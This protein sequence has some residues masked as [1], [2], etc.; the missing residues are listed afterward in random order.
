M[1]SLFSLSSV[2]LL[3]GGRL[4]FKENLRHF[5]YIGVFLMIG[6]A[7]I[8]SFSNPGGGKTIEV[9]G[10]TITTIPSYQAVLLGL[11]CPLIF[12]FRSTMVR[13][14]K[15]K[16]D[17]PP[18]DLTVATFTTLNIVLG[19]VSLIVIPGKGIPFE[20]YVR[21]TFC[22]FFG[23]IGL[24]LINKA[25]TIGYAGPVSALCSI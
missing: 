18:F 2:F 11:I 1:S 20:V 25:I 5:H 21:C 17:F 24:V 23:L 9:E 6:C 3:I 15:M 7:I 19:I 8:I 13:I 22:S 16:V 14:Y 4:I 12:A 10:F